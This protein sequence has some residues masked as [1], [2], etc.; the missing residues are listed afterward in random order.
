MS[1]QELNAYLDEQIRLV[2]EKIQD[3]KHAP[4]DPDDDVSKGKLLVYSSIKNS[5][6]KEKLSNQELGVL[7]AVND[8]L[9]TLGLLDH[10]TTLPAFI[11][12]SS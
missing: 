9:Q 7:G 8:V 11:R 3:D 4:G 12:Q 6:R 10:K 5:V 1:T 2:T